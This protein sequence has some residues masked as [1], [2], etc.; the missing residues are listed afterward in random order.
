MMQNFLTQAAL[1]GRRPRHLRNTRIFERAALITRLT[2]ERSVARF[3]VAPTGFG[4]MSLLLEYAQS[5]FSCNHVFWVRCD[6]SAF[7]RDLDDS[8]V[9]DGIK[10][11]DPRCS[12]VV[13]DDVPSLD[14]TRRETFISTIDR[15]LQEGC[16]VLVS[17]TCIADSFECIRDRALIGANDLLLSDEELEA[18]SALAATDDVGIRATPKAQRVAGL[19]WADA[20]DSELFLKNILA[21]GLSS[22]FILPMFLMLV[23]GSAQIDELSRFHRVRPDVLEFLGKHYAFL[24]IGEVRGTFAAAPFSI[25]LVAKVFRERLHELAKRSR[26]QTEKALVVALAEVLCA[27]GD[28][29]RAADTVRLLA[30]PQQRTAWL[31]KHQTML[32]DECCLVAASALHAT[33]PLS[34]VNAGMYAQEAVRQMLLDGKVGAAI[35]AKRALKRA[36]KYGDHLSADVLLATL[37]LIACTIGD[38]HEAVLTEARKLVEQASL[39]CES[40]EF[41]ASGKGKD[42][43]R[44]DRS[45]EDGSENNHAHPI[46]PAGASA[47]RLAHPIDTPSTPHDIPDDASDSG[48]VADRI[49]AL[50][51][52]IAL[53]ESLERAA[54]MWLDAFEGTHLSTT[55]LFS[56]AWLLKAAISADG[57][58]FAIEAVAA[59]LATATSAVFAET[60]ELTLP[61]AIA[62]LSFC[63]ARAAHIVDLPGLSSD[64]VTAARRIERMW[65]MQKTF[66]ARERRSNAEAAARRRATTRDPHAKAA[67]KS[68]HS[69]PPTLTVNLFGCMDVRIGGER[70]DAKQFHRT[71]VR[72]LLALLVLHRG[73][74]LSRRMLAEKFYPHD[75][76]DK[77]LANIS[78]LKSKLVCALKTPSG[79][80]PYIIEDQ[81]AF[82]LDTSLLQSDVFEIDAVCDS[83]NRGSLSDSEWSCLL[84]RAN[85]PFGDD[86]MPG[87]AGD[88]T[89]EPVRQRYREKLVDAFVSASE[90]LVNAG[91]PRDAL[92]FARAA[93]DRDSKREDVYYTLMKAQYTAM[94]TA[95][96]IE[97]Y[98]K[99][100][101]YL[102]NELGMDPSPKTVRL[103]RKMLDREEVATR[104]LEAAL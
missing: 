82:G 89:I 46:E 88:F 60:A 44:E 5:L 31:A 99:C 33:L 70:V 49:S 67:E 19:V 38:A 79:D 29:V 12:L 4:K 77:G 97:T 57:A 42:G 68:V 90:L 1:H 58:T 22:E 59:S 86:L 92:M 39:A 78:A 15:L 66:A 37:C 61:Q 28:P 51:V 20:P 35:E 8:F 75:S 30:R 26:L 94:Q 24:G 56:G 25:E 43:K 62:V 27:H 6:S 80:C 63:N 54:G 84:A 13:F 100:S 52:A 93:Y 72:L 50:N 91:R 104:K 17:C 83:L 9:Y 3:V 40:A 95:S 81:G 36:A 45:G 103:Y 14:D 55:A 87:D 41:I 47:G 74:R 98:I 2:H 18:S 85:D 11:A 48:R 16:E 23:L 32:L 53:E 102:S 7:L 65:Q 21:E 64:V 101:R 10:E 71:K 96:A 34:K 73:H 69:R 76:M